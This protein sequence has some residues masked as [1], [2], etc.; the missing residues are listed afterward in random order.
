V[1]VR[2][3][4]AFLDDLNLTNANP[5]QQVITTSGPS[6]L[7]P[8]QIISPRILRVGARLEW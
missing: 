2:G 4:G 3:S 7:R 6:F 5:E 1:I 8:T